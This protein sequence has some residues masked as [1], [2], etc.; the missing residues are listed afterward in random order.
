MDPIKTG[1]S[2]HT[3]LFEFVPSEPGTLWCEAQNGAG[4]S[5]TSVSIFILEK[6]EHFLIE[7]EPEQKS[8]GN[9]VTINCYASM[10]NFTDSLEMW[11]N[12]S[13]VPVSKGNT[14]KHTIN[15]PL[16]NP[17]ICRRSPS[18]HV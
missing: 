3:A 8:I 4:N 17:S 5:S 2:T 6:D 18:I 11:F 12:G 7:S 10:Y 15:N 14:I 9:N 13:K 1:P 16:L